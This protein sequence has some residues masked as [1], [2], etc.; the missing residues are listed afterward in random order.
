VQFGRYIL[1]KLLMIFAR[2]FIP[3]FLLVFIASIAITFILPETYASRTQIMLATNEAASRGEELI[4]DSNSVPRAIQ[5]ILSQRVLEHVIEE[6]NLNEIW[7]KEY[8]AG[9]KLKSAVTMQLL[10]QRLEVRPIRNTRVIGVTVYSEDRDEAAQIANE[11]G[12]SYCVYL[13]QTQDE[14]T[15]NVPSG[16]RLLPGTPRLVE[17]A[18]PGRKPVR[19]NKVLNLAIGAAAGILLGAIAGGIFAGLASPLGRKASAV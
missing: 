6:L 11:I 7:G 17:L 1:E 10:K 9:V 4:A 13:Y 12:N 3:V 16:A 15:T 2:V 19:P 14:L 5:D 8:N 18:K